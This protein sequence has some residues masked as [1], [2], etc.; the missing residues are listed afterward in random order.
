MQI[1]VK[2][3]IGDVT[4]DVEPTDT[5]AIVKDKICEKQGMPVEQMQLVFDKQML[6]DERATVSQCNIA[7]ESTIHVFRVMDAEGQGQS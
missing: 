2:A 3:L 4:I 5:I 6:C 7:G 1:V